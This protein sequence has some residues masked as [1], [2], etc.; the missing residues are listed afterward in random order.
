MPIT[1]PD[2]RGTRCASFASCGLVKTKDSAI[3]KRLAKQPDW[4]TAR[5]RYKEGTVYVRAGFGGKT[6]THCHVE[7]ADPILLRK[8]P[9]VTHKLSQIQDILEHLKGQEIVCD[10]AGDFL[11][12][13]NKLPRFVQAM[14]L[15]I[16]EGNVS[17]R[18]ASGRFE[19]TGAPVNSITW[20]LDGERKNALLKLEATKTM[21]VDDSYLVDG[22]HVML[23]GF[24]AFTGGGMPH[25][26]E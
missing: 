12:E 16:E 17:F 13:T 8:A 14:L 11:L 5:R 1:L 21:V 2:L 20:A 26:E 22:L 18:A 4:M 23:S 6:G 7:V 19:V 24:T 25:G 10:L 9:K 3:L 15:N